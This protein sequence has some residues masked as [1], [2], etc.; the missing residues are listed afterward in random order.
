[1]KRY[2]DLLNRYNVSTNRYN[3]SE[4]V[5]TVQKCAT[6]TRVRV[7]AA[8]TRAAGKRVRVQR[9]FPKKKTDRPFSNRYG[10]RG[11]TGTGYTRRVLA[12]PTIIH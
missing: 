1:M 3:D 6:G 9:V 8:G 7:Q 11:Y 4:T 12:N 2:N 5:I 10:Y